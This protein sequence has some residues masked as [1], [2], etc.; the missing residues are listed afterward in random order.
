MDSKSGKQFEI[1]DCVICLDPMKD[2]DMMQRVPTCKHMFHPNCLKEWF[3]S[4][5]Q[6]D[7]QR[8][9]QCNQVLKTTEMKAAKA[10]NRG[11]GDAEV[12]QSDSRVHPMQAVGALNF[13]G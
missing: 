4:K 8:C 7:E 11:N 1:V 5:A 3:E 9:P 10:K 2:G 12:K 13:H 6:E